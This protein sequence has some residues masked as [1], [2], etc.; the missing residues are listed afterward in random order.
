[1][2]ILNHTEFCLCPLLSP[3]LLISAQVQ[4]AATTSS[5]FANT[6]YNTLAYTPAGNKAPTAVQL[7]GDQDP[8]KSVPYIQPLQSHATLTVLASHISATMCYCIDTTTATAAVAMLQGDAAKGTPVSLQQ[9][10][11]YR[12][13]L[14]RVRP[15]HCRSSYRLLP[16]TQ[17]YTISCFTTRCPASSAYAGMHWSPLLPYRAA[18]KQPC[19][20]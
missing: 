2:L 18:S 19:I 5:M 7:P 8:P 12:V 4:I 9:W 3:R 10:L 11:C 13:M 15:C 6:L 16:Q 14:Q 20:C 17:A 1:M